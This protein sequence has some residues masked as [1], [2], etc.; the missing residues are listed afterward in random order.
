MLAI[1][2]GE[3]FDWDNNKFKPSRKVQSAYEVTSTKVNAQLELF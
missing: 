3:V 1:K 2:D